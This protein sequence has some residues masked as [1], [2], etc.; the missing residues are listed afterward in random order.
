M[1]NKRI[2]T[3]AFHS[4]CY[5]NSTKTRLESEEGNNYGIGTYHSDHPTFNTDRMDAV[6]NDFISKEVCELVDIKYTASCSGNNPPTNF[7][8]VTIIYIPSKTK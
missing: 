5:D 8:F 2:K 4:R 6:I 7:T 1:E 3:F